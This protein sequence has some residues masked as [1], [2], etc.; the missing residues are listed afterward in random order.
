M[1]ASA[2]WNGRNAPTPF[3]PLPIWKSVQLIPAVGVL[4]T[5]RPLGF[6][7]QRVFATG[8]Q[9]HHE[10]DSGRRQHTDTPALLIGSAAAGLVLLVSRKSVAAAAAASVLAV[11]V[12]PAKDYT[13]IHHRKPRTPGST[14]TVRNPERLVVDL[15]RP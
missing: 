7:W 4:S 10:P 2:S 8:I 1:T 5:L 3:F 12:W 6:E 11:R 15:R 14:C 9:A 13:R